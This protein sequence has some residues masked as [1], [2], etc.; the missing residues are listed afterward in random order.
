VC[1]CIRQTTLILVSAVLALLVPGATAAETAPDHSAEFA[2]W[3]EQLS[4]SNGDELRAAWARFGPWWREHRTA[5]G[6]TA[7]SLEDLWGRRFPELERALDYLVSTGPTVHEGYNLALTVLYFYKPTVEDFM[8][9]EEFYKPAFVRLVYENRVAHGLVRQRGPRLDPKHDPW[10]EVVKDVQ[11]KREPG[12]FPAEPVVSPLQQDTEL[13]LRQ[14]LLPLLSFFEAPHRPSMEGGN[15]SDIEIT[16]FQLQGLRAARS[17]LVNGYWLGVDVTAG[18]FT[19]AD[20]SGAILRGCT[21]VETVLDRA[22]TD[23]ATFRGCQ[24]TEVRA[25][26]LRAYRTMF[27]GCEAREGV[28]RG[29]DF[30]RAVFQDGD[31]A[32]ADFN[33]ALLNGVTFT[34]C[35]LRNSSFAGA[36]LDG[37]S[38]ERCQLED[39]D[40]SGAIWRNAGEELFT[41]CSLHGAHLDRSLKPALSRQ[42]RK[43]IQFLRRSK[44]R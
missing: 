8:L 41:E 25:R 18:D 26:G 16:E 10:A 9:E 28:F 24:I 44:R 1:N 19:A 40:F 36:T 5:L 15:L 21:M 29:A 42:Q 11:K 17:T 43:Q 34:A 13:S 30:N 33:G 35:D 20:L 2:G 14:V 3:Y 4:R 22:R 7:M 38:F 31:L 27:T 32:G 37:V 39:V 12:T 23:R 6:Q